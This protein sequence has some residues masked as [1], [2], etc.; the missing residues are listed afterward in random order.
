MPASAKDVKVLKSD[1][2]NAETPLERL[3]GLLTPVEMFYVRNH[4]AIATAWKSLSV[5][6]AVANP[7]QLGLDDLRA[8]PRRTVTATLECA[9]NGRAFQQPPAA[10][11]QWGLGAVATAEWGGTPLRSVLELARIE[12][13]AAEVLFTGA[14]RGA[15]ETGRPPVAFERSLPRRTALSD[16]PLL[17]YEMNGRPLLPEHGAPLRLVVPGWYGMASVKWLVRVTALERPFEGF[18]QATHYILDDGVHEPAP[19]VEMAVRAL[20]TFPTDGA[21]LAAGSAA[22]VRGYA[23]SGAAEVEGVDLSTDGGRSWEPGEL[24]PAPRHAW[25]EWRTSWTP[26]G[27]GEFE[28][29]ARATD[30]GGNLQPDKAPWNRLGYRNNAVRP[31]RVSVR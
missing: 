6:G 7:I 31:V 5:Q 25:H 15:P 10:G 12:A 8:L 1:P 9:G 11:V 4:F 16:E 2:F 23:W 26:A 18:F 19:L 29:R 17:V 27:P 20:I 28:L 13:E 22:A 24:L 30:A 21:V 14:D 3:Q